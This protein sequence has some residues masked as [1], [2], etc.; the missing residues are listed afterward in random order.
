MTTII[1]VLKR[2]G[3]GLRLWRQAG[4]ARREWWRIVWRAPLSASVGWHARVSGPVTLGE[5]TVIHDFAHLA[6]GLVDPARERITLGYGCMVHPHAQI[7]SWGG[8][9]ELGQRCSVNAGAVL[10]GTGGLRIGDWVR[11]AANSVIVASAHHFDDPRSPIAGQ[12]YAA[13]GI[14][15]EDD[16]WIGAGACVL[17]GVRIGRGAVVGAGA[18]VTRDVAPYT[19]V[20]GVPAK[21]IGSR[22]PGESS[23]SAAEEPVSV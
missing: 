18:V 22:S 8:T 1:T 11:I 23:A 14:V 12:G 9:V 3:R 15:I 19:I 21:P 6:A 5:R 17:D 10:Y 7:H 2:A 16:V 13:T 20:G 4:A